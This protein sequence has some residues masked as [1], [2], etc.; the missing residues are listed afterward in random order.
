MYSVIC[1]RKVHLFATEKYITT[2][3]NL[4]C[5]LVQFKCCDISENN[6]KA[7]SQGNPN[8]NQS[9]LK[10][11]TSSHN[12]E[13]IFEKESIASNDIISEKRQ[14]RENITK[15]QG[16]SYERKFMPIKSVSELKEL[17]ERFTKLTATLE[18]ENIGS[19]D[20]MHHTIQN[21]VKILEQQFKEMQDRNKSKIYM[22]Q[23]NR[24]IALN[25]D[26]KSIENKSKVV[27]MERKQKEIKS[28]VSCELHDIK[29]SENEQTSHPSSILP[30]TYKNNIAVTHNYTNKL[31]GIND[32]LDEMISLLIEINVIMEDNIE[33]P[34]NLEKGNN[35]VS[36]K[37]KTMKEELKENSCL[38]EA[39]KSS[40]NDF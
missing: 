26:G 10:Y 12:Q 1:T 28:I 20:T 14:N 34:Y 8:K 4:L 37:E 32:I 17:F 25:N 30:N 29:A 3:I 2:T 11:K 38:F 22:L 21:R 39:K 33:K 9:I 5:Y 15:D 35:Q 36:A 31:C 19:I 40:E 6:E 27:P 16:F 23:R 24:I 7:I 13:N 18:Q